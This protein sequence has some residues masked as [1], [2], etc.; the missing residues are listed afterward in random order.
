MLYDLWIINRLP[1]LVCAQ[2][3]NANP[4]FRSYQKGF[5]S[6]KSIRAKKTLASAIQIG[7]PVSVKKAIRALQEFDGIVGE[8]SENE[9]ANAVGRANKTGLLCCPHTGVALAVL[10]KLVAGGVIQS[11]HRVVVISTANGLKFTDF[12][13]KYHAG[14]LK[15]VQGEFV[16]QPVEL[17]ADIQRVREIISEKLEM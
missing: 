7:S 6:F 5:K 14:K 10:E 12:L 17:P 15:D 11:K 8:A 2:A 9:L 1:R 3:Q 4:L 13:A 16:F